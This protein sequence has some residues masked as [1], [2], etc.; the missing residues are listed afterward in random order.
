MSKFVV[1]K[2]TADMISKANELE[3]TYGEKLIEEGVK[4]F[5]RHDMTIKKLDENK[6]EVITKDEE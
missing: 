2:T 1:D 3:G 4:V 5:L 6:Y